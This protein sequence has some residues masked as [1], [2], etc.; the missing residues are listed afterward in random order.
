MILRASLLLFR[1]RGSVKNALPAKNIPD[2]SWNIPG[3]FP[4]FVAAIKNSITSLNTNEKKSHQAMFI[5]SSGDA[6]EDIAPR[7]CFELS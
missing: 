2:F 7:L 3:K 4:I 6:D 5:Q 1:T